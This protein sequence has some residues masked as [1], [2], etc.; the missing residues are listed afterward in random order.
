MSVKRGVP[1]KMS[2]HYFIETQPRELKFC[3]KMS[4]VS[5]FECANFGFHSVRIFVVGP[6]DDQKLLCKHDE[7]WHLSSATCQDPVNS[8]TRQLRVLMSV[9]KQFD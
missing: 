1:K 6:K 9:D 8:S 3:M 2:G 4:L 5:G 7:L